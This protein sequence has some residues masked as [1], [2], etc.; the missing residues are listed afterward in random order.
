M[1]DSWAK[2]QKGIVIFCAFVIGMVIIIYSID[3]LYFWGYE[4]RIQPNTSY[5]ASDWIGFWGSLAG[6]LCGAIIAIYGV[7]WTIENNRIESERILE[8]NRVINATLI[9]ENRNLNDENSRKSILPVIAIN[10]LLRRYDGNFFGALVADA[11]PEKEVTAKDPGLIEV[12]EM[13]YEE[14]KIESLYFTITKSNIDVTQELSQDQQVHIK[15]GWKTGG[16]M[17]MP[18]FVTNCGNGAAINTTFNLVKK[19]S[20]GNIGAISEPV[21][22]KKEADFKLGVYCDR[23]NDFFGSYYLKI[24]YYDIHGEK[25]SQSHLINIDHEKITIST[26]IIQKHTKQRILQKTGLS[27]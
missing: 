14:N 4:Q 9:Q 15:N 6:G 22:L 1:K 10:K 20:V 3:R 25:Y 27:I 16:I 5:S 19:N 12:K 18:C 24:A 2:Y 21:N 7:Y 13:E 23:S 26:K 17:Y 11:Y 8:H